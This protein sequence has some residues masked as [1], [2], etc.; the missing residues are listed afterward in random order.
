MSDTSE[1]LAV[2]LHFTGIDMATFLLVQNMITIFIL[3]L[4]F[5]AFLVRTLT[6]TLLLMNKMCCIFKNNLEYS[7]RTDVKL[8]FWSATIVFP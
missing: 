1:F 5:N 3:L 6:L 4:L 8:N 2:N 7:D